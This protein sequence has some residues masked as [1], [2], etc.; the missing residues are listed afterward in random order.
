EINRRADNDIAIAKQAL[1]TKLEDYKEFQKTEEQLL[2]ES[3]NRKKF[4]AA[5]DLELSKFEQKQA[6]ELL[7]QQKQQELGL[8]KLAQ[9]QRLFQARLSLL[10]ETQ[11]MQERYRLEREE[12]LKNTKLSIEERQK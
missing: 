5:H 3:F 2:E 6:V 1:R 11:A 8:L 10:S 4:N 9:E 7:E 12:I